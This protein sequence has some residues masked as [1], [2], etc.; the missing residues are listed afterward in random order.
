MSSN[1]CKRVHFSVKSTFMV[2]EITVYKHYTTGILDIMQIATLQ[3]V[4]LFISLQI[5]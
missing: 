4:S 3:T 1:Q 5:V 2:L